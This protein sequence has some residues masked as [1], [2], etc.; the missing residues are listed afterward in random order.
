MVW[1]PAGVCASSF[2]TSGRKPRSSISSASSSTTMRAWASVRC[3]CWARSS[4]RPGVPTTTS[5][6][7]RQRLDLRLVGAA[8]VDGEHP[9][10]AA[11]CRR[12][13]GRR[14]PGRRVR[15]WARRR[16]PAACRA[17]RARRS[18]PR[19]G[20]RRAAAAGMPKP[21]VLP[22]PVLAWPM[23]SW[24]A[25]AT[26]R[27]MAWMGKG[28]VMPTPASG[29]DDRGLDAEVGEGGEVVERA[30]QLVGPCRVVG[31]RCRSRWARMR[32]WS[33]T[34]SWSGR[35]PHAE[36]RRDVPRRAAPLGRGSRSG[37]R[38]VIRICRRLPG[39]I[40]GRPRDLYSVT[41][42]RRPALPDRGWPRASVACGA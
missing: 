26:G 17:R 42:R 13:R 16:G 25:S 32:L 10:R 20:R 29:L 35:G 24:P 3:F 21:R 33:R 37:T 27:V 36:R 5:T 31:S 1:R 39:S 9:D 41:A 22:V 30:L 6:P 12:W 7:L 14:R 11:A 40:G 34:A 8:A 19:R 18:R 15:G 23:M 28:W 2:S 4:S 38:P